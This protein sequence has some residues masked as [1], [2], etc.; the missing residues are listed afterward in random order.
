MLDKN[1]QD[2][3]ISNGRAFMRGYRE[4]DPYAESFES[5]QE[6]KLPQPPLVKAAVAAKGFLKNPHDS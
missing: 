6:L 1:I 2:M 3:L 5:D 4:D